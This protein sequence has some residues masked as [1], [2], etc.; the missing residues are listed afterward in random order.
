MNKMVNW[1][2]G[3]VG[4]INYRQA[5]HGGGV[6]DP[7]AVAAVLRRHPVDGQHH[8]ARRTHQHH[9]QAQLPTVLPKEPK[10]VAMVKAVGTWVQI[11]GSPYF[12]MNGLGTFR[13]KK[14]YMYLGK[15]V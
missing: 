6:D 15:Q 9:V 3:D 11:L 4:F 2:F 5:G 14:L 1:R 13:T 7:A 12:L 10:N 8:A